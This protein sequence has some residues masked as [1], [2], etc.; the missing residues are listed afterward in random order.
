MARAATWRLPSDSRS[1]FTMNSPDPPPSSRS[2]SSR[3]ELSEILKSSTISRDRLMSVDP[4]LPHN[5][6]PATFLP[7]FDQPME[8]HPHS[9]GHLPVHTYDNDKLDVAEHSPYDLFPH[10]PQPS[11]PHQ[12]LR[13]NTSPAAPTYGHNSEPIYSNMF[14][15]DSVHSF[16]SQS[17]YDMMSSISSSLSSGK[18]TPLTPSDHNGSLPFSAGP[19]NGIKQDFTDLISDRRLSAVNSNGFHPDLPDDFPLAVNSHPNF[20][21]TLPSFSDR[22]TRFPQETFLSQSQMQG[23]PHDQLRGVPPQATHSHSR[24]EG[25]PTYDEIPNYLIPNPSNDL[26]LRIPSVGDAMMGMRMGQIGAATDL[27]TFIR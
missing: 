26:S 15:H 23:H 11:F 18:G 7:H 22:L 9:A 16:H 12:R 27:Q 5:T 17:P 4:A 8:S 24:F 19:P 3:W 20:G 14:P 2:D 13:S 25:G 10:P 6:S 1:D 21:S